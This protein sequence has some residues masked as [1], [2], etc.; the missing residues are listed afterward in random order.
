MLQ[1]SLQ[2][3]TTKTAKL[4]RGREGNSKVTGYGGFLVVCANS[5]EPHRL[6]VDAGGSGNGATDV[7]VTRGGAGLRAVNDDILLCCTG[8]VSFLGTGYILPCT[9]HTVEL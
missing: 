9:A 7:Q 1:V 5:Y 6:A 3:K 8:A 4:T 2:I